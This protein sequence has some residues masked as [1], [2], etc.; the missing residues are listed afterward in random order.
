MYMVI[1]LRLQLQYVQH[2]E[3]PRVLLQCLFLGNFTSRV[4]HLRGGG[5]VLNGCGVGLEA[6]VGVTVVT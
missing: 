4:T 1:F 2:C 6:K 5:P 3:I